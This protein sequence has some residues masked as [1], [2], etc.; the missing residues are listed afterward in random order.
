MASSP[1]LNALQLELLEGWFEQSGDFFLTGG[2]ALVFGL[3]MPRSTQDLDLFT[4][5]A[6]AFEHIDLRVAALARS[7]GAEYCSLRTAP[8]FHRYRLQRADDTSLLDLVVDP[9]PPV[10]PAK[11]LKE[12]VVMD[13]PEEILLNKICSIVGRAEGRDFV[14]TYFLASR[15]L[16]VEAALLEANRKDGGVDAGT[17]LYVLSDINWQRFQVP[18]VETALVEATRSF[19]LNWMESLARRSFPSR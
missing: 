7:V 9:V 1:G 18:G 6:A 10:H 4:D 8:Q 14:D 17:L 15:G 12:K 19:F 2:A 16:D 3:G 11:W 5:S 13:P